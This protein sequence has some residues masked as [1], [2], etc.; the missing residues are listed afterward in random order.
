MRVDTL[1]KWTDFRGEVVAISRVGAMSKGT[2]SKG[3]KGAKGGDK[4]NHQT[5]QTCPR[6]GSTDH[7]SANCPHSDKTC[8]KCEKVCHLASA[9]RSS[10][11]PQPKASGGGKKGKGGKSAGTAKTCWNCGE[12][13]HLSSQCPK[14]KVHAGVDLT[15][16]K[17][18]G[19][20]GHHHGWYN[21]KLL[22][23][24]QCG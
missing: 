14:K 20:P 23:P 22:R 13:G 18:S 4:R 12:N 10:G 2:S 17:P 21:W 24:W 6:C 7:T 8:R 9:C 1:K 3:G 11:T 5:Q 19:Q 16:A 15:T